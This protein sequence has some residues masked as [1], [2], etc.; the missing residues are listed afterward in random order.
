MTSIHSKKT[1]KIIRI[2]R[3]LK[4]KINICAITIWRIVL[5]VRASLSAEGENM[6]FFIKR[7]FYT[8]FSDD[9]K[10]LYHNLIVKFPDINDSFFP[11]PMFD[12]NQRPNLNHMGTYYKLL[13]YKTF[14]STIKENDVFFRDNGINP[15]DILWSEKNIPCATLPDQIIVEHGWLPRSSYQISTKGA[16]SRGAIARTREVGFI[17]RIGGQKNVLEKISNLRSCIHYKS[18]SE[19]TDLPLEYIVAPLQTGDDLN[20]K[21]SGTIFE[22]YHNLPN[23]SLKFGQAFINHIESSKLPFPVIFTQH[24]A[25]HSQLD[26][27]ISRTDNRFISNRFGLRTIDLLAAS[28]RCKGIISINSNVIHEALCLGI[29]CCCLGRLL[30]NDTDSPP[31]PSTIT[32][33]INK[34]DTNILDDALILEYLAKIL[35]FQWYLSDFQNPMIILNM[36]QQKDLAIPLEIRRKF[37]FS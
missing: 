11:H 8:A 20:L 28:K 9:N 26:Y 2:W 21:Y 34:L 16:N 24:P 33:L 31:L 7:Y 6:R 14:I 32:E 23:S 13:F 36:L 15:I 22:R 18:L 25:D 37:A 10:D 5:A 27:H 3:L 29:P 12:T 17:E 30:W 4:S 1:T 19:Y 35:S